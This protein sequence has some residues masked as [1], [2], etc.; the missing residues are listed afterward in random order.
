MKPENM[1]TEACPICASL[2]IWPFF[3]VDQVPVHCHLL[4]A[5]REQALQVPKADIKLGYCRECSH[6]FNLVFEPHLMD[7]TPDYENSLHF[8]PRFQTY[9]EALAGQLIEK[10]HL[11]NKDI[12][13]I[14]CG[15]ADFLRLLCELG[16]NRGSGFDPSCNPNQ[17][18]P[19]K[20]GSL[21]LIRDLYS[22]A[23]AHYPADLIACRHVLEHIDAPVEFLTQLRQ[24]IG[25][26]LNTALFF[27]VP[28]ALFMLRD[29]SI[30][31][32]IY[33]HCAYYSP[34]AL[35]HLFRRC[36]FQVRDS[37]ESYRGQ[38]L[39]IE[40]TPD[41]DWVLG[42]TYQ[43]SADEIE[44]F[45]VPSQRELDPVKPFHVAAFA[46]QYRYQ[47]SA[48]QAKIKQILAAGHR[49]VVWG[50]GSKGVMFLN[51]LGHLVEIEYIVDIN[52]RK[53]GM[54]V[55]GSGQKIVPPTFLQHY[56]PEFVILMNP[57]Y[58]QEVMSMLKNLGVTSEVLLDD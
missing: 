14:G 33:E 24:L 2:D 7:Y 58:R 40:V 35:S 23:Y 32:I 9:A 43:I 38:F 19:T 27:E 21:N 20:R 28:N 11:Y 30:W 12:I 39:C 50:A 15:K 34:Q 54:Y 36:G 8:S 49:V 6:I 3:Q 1:C 29:L 26:R 13:E 10:Y 46:D 57:V 41:P 45:L 22:S 51:A 47:V 53:E 56:Q 5:Q 55:A 37:Y 31:D 44:S 17:L 16:D 4:C 48:Y 18:D 42:Q 52:P 25:P